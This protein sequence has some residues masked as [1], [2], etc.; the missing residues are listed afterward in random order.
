[1]KVLIISDGHGDLD[2]LDAV[3]PIA[4]TCDLVLFAGDFARFGHLD[5]AKPFLDR[6]AKLH[7]QVFAV[8]GNCDSPDFREEVDQLGLSVE[9]SLSFFSGLL[10]AGSGG[11]VRHK[12]VTPNERDDEDLA[13]DLHLAAGSAEEAEVAEYE[14]DDSEDDDETEDVKTEDARTGDGSEL[15]ADASRNAEGEQKLR[16]NLVVIAH[17][18]PVNTLLDLIPGGTHAGL[19]SDI[20]AGSPGIR[21]FIETERPLLA[22]SGHIHEGRAVDTL[23]GTTLVNPGP[24]CDGF[25]AVAEIT[26][27]KNSPFKVSSVKLEQL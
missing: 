6:L 20:H 15:A 3:A 22:V 4:E 17:H 18:P 10:L 12:G 19:P 24:L 25:Y 7:D 1:M 16:D 2:R 21:A 8:T 23:N 27:G 14:A 9:G 5:T 26:G 13:A 11:G